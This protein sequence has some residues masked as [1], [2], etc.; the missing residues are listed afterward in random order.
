MAAPSSPRSVQEP[1]RPAALLLDYLRGRIVTNVDRR[2]RETDS[3][4]QR[5][6]VPPRVSRLVGCGCR[7]SLPRRSCPAAPRPHR[8]RRPRRR[9]ADLLPAL[10]PDARP[11]SRGRPRGADHGCGRPDRGTPL[12]GVADTLAPHLTEDHRRP[13]QADHRA[14]GR[15]VTPARP[16]AGVSVVWGWSARVWR[17]TSSRLRVWSAARSACSTRSRVARRA[18]GA[19][20]H[21]RH[22]GAVRRQAPRSTTAAASPPRSTT[23]RH[24]AVGGRCRARARSR[25]KASTTR[26]SAARTSRGSS[27]RCPVPWAASAPAPGRS[28]LR[29]APGQPRVDEGAALLAARVL[30]L[31][32]TLDALVFGAPYRWTTSANTG[33]L[34]PAV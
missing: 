24:A 27:T 1:L 20:L 16:A 32:S 2:H 7:S 33:A 18:P 29:P 28:D 26:A 15:D 17:P 22:R 5:R 34:A 9:R 6:P 10:R 11:R 19:R 8:P 21:R 14:A 31:R 13:R 23:R 25:G 12:P 30:A 4:S 3:E